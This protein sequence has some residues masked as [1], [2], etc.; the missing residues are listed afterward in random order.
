MLKRLKDNVIWLL[1][2]VSALVVLFISIYTS[3]L[4]N[5]TFHMLETNVEQRLIVLSKAAADLVTAEELG[6][7][8][9]PEDMQK[10]LFDDVRWRLTRFSDENEVLYTYFMRLE[11]DR[12]QFIA[13]NDPDPETRVDLS[14]EPVDSEPAVE[15]ALGGVPASS[16]IGNYSDNWNGILSAYAP[17]YDDEGNVVAIAGVDIYD[18]QIIKTRNSMTVMTIVQVASMVVVILTG[19]LG[20]FLYSKKAKQSEA[21]NVAKSQFLSRMSHEIRTP[22][23]AI[24][25]LCRM[26]RDAND[27]AAQVDYMDKID[28]ASLHLLRLINDILDLSKIES[29]KL[30]LEAVPAELYTEIDSIIKIIQPQTDAKGQNFRREVAPDLPR[31]VLCDPT[32]LRQIV[33]NLLSNAIKFTPEGGEI[34]LGVQLMEIRGNRCHLAW[35]VRDNGIGIEHGSINKLFAPFEQG[36]G[37]TTRRYGG[38][39]LGLAI[40]KQLVEMMDGKIGVHSIVGEGSEFYFDTWLQLA[41]E[42]EEQAAPEPGQDPALPPPD[43]QGKTVLVV[44]DSEI[45]QLIAEDLFTSMGAEVHLASNGLAAF[46]SY[47]KDHDRYDIIFMDIQMPVMDGYE[48]TRQIRASGIPGADTIPIIAMTANVFREDVQQAHEAGMNAHVGKPIEVSQVEAAIRGV[49]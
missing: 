48:A 25:G 32:H 47:V 49:L 36:D 37:S 40:S 20:L 19:L 23:N 2:F 27:P 10:N 35:S 4:M 39:G 45:N 34:T 15:S 22:L 29:G 28:A 21:A 16:S 7:L 17:V 30:A 31:R 5:N 13:D 43:L 1:F 26:A 9:T 24:I 33:V 18:E 12:M 46:E 44:E 6:E 38:T 42:P 11:D 14:T 8:Q 41:P 3:Q